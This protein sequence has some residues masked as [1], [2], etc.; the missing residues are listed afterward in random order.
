MIVLQADRSRGPQPGDL[1]TAADG[2][3]VRSLTDL[4]RALQGR[5]PGD[6][7][8]LTWRTPDGQTKRGSV[9]VRTKLEDHEAP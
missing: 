5:G 2:K 3:P 9:E 7:I 1:I 4:M 8:R 6:E